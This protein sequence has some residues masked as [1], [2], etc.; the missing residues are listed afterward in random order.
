MTPTIVA[1]VIAG[2]VL[3]ASWRLL[4]L[5]RRPSVVKLSL[6]LLLQL[7]SAILLWVLLYPPSAPESRTQLTVLAADASADQFTADDWTV[8]LPEAPPVAGIERV[9]D[10]ATALRQ[11][12]SVRRIR[13]VGAALTARDLDAARRVDVDFIPSAL[14]SGL[15]QLSA[16]RSLPAGA[17]WQIHGRV[18]AAE[19]ARVELVDP[20]GERIAMADADTAGAFELRAAVRIPGRMLY[21]L[22]VL[23]GEEILEEVTLPVVVDPGHRARVLILAGGSNPEFKYLRRWA[24]ESG[25]A[26]RW[27]LNLRP[28]VRVLSDETL[29]TAENLRKT[30]LLIL[31]ER[32]RL[33]LRDSDRALIREAVDAGLGLLL[34]L[35]SV[36][37][38]RLRDSFAGLGFKVEN[39]DIARSVPWS[40]QRTLSAE[41]D[42]E[43]APK[44]SLTRRSVRVSADDAAILQA[45]DHGEPLALWRAQAQGRIGLWWLSDSF[46]LV[47]EGQ[48]AAHGALWANAFQTLARARSTSGAA[49]EAIEARIHTRVSLCDLALE[50][51]VIAPDAT[52][53]ELIPDAQGQ[54]CAGWWPTQSGWHQVQTADVQRDIY[55]RTREEAPGLLAQQ[56]RESTLALST[57]AAMAT[58]HNAPPAGEPVSRWWWWSAW[59]LSLGLLW[60]LER[61]WLRP[62]VSQPTLG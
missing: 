9:P 8:A 10:L 35:T 22:R 58:S 51:A 38:A 27:S 29:L 28:G 34:R 30:D 56:L 33:A 42:E 3:I 39:A 57:R 37:D 12:P 16:P 55:V 11:Y 14:P 50:S 5:E 7:A 60:W 45:D 36:V 48:R 21:R 18:H 2:I 31:D 20:A 41:R 62:S 24:I 47:L 17:I 19:A 61:R 26:V 43:S 59:I 4:R 53:V 40:T 23:R 52:R 1:G 49:D 32:A 25:T 54:N 13:V 46:R 44:L 15:V 6:L